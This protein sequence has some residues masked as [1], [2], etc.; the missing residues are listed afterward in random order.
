M[1]LVAERRGLAS[2][3]SSSL[4]ALFIEHVTKENNDKIKFAVSGRK[5]NS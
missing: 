4:P 3:L 1:L 2:V 5:K